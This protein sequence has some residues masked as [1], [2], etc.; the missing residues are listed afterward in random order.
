MP[1]PKTKILFLASWYPSKN[2]PVEGIFVQKHAEAAALF[3][4]ISVLYLTLYTGL[5]G[6]IIEVAP[7]YENNVYTVRVYL[8]K[9]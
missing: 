9:T 2:S 1:T 7:I 6:K 5:N 4:D 3:S 8:S